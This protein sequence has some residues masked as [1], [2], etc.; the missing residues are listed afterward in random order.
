MCMRPGGRQAEFLKE[1]CVAVALPG[2]NTHVLMTANGKPVKDLAEFNA[3][4][5]SERKPRELLPNTKIT[6]L[7]GSPIYPLDEDKPVAPPNGA[8]VV[9]SY[10]RGL[11]RREGAWVS[12]GDLARERLKQGY[13]GVAAIEAAGPNR[14]FLWL[15]ESEWKS[16]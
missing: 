9:R 11:E 14:D 6:Y 4:P 5:E 1:H 8:L 10:V 3:L 16:L 7:N 12:R 15:L 2:G 13:E